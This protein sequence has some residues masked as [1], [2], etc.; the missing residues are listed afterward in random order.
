MYKLLIFLK[1]TGDESVLVRFN[2][3]TIPKLERLAGKKVS[4]AEIEGALLS[5]EKFEKFCEASFTD[6]SELDRL[7]QTPLGKELNKD[8][9]AFGNHISVFYANFGE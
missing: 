4:S 2:E 1:K 5:P 7:L 9:A 3:S 6:K 8:L